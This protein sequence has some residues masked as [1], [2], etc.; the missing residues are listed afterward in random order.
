VVRTAFHDD[1]NKPYSRKIPQPVEPEAIA[2]AIIDGIETGKSRR[3][4]PGWI[5]IAVTAQRR[6]PRVFEV[7][8]RLLGGN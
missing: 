1:R 4:V 7:M 8:S 5:E 2:A 6:V 3:T